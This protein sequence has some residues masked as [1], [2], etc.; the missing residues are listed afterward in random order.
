MTALHV[1]PLSRL[2]D[3]IASSGASHA[4][5][6]LSPEQ[7]LP[8]LP[9][10]LSAHRLILRFNDI[11]E[12][13][14]G[15]IAPSVEHVEALL[16]FARSWNRVKPLLFHCYAG[17]SRSTAAAYICACASMPQRAE[18]EIASELRTASPSA[19]PNPRMIALADNILNRNGRMISAIAR[20][21]RGAEAFE[22][23][24]FVIP[25]RPDFYSTE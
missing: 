4:V 10:F 20:I 18:E 19:T 8:V 3:T 21:G 13:M 5:T 7:E 23:T 2:D 16:D 9:T 17:I 1:C 24:P 15:Y 25:L 22:G 14:P 6:L 12:P 11:A